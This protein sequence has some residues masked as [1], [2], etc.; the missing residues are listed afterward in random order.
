[1]HRSL[2][3]LLRLFILVCSVVIRN[4]HRMLNS[5]HNIQSLL[6]TDNPSRNKFGCKGINVL[7][8]VICLINY[9]WSK[10]SKLGQTGVPF[11]VLVMFWG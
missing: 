3:L 6:E 8:H 11:P 2:Y 7:R 9:L 4:I 1:M 5:G 10:S